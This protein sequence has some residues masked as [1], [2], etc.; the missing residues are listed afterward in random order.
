MTLWGFLS[1]ALWGQ[2]PASPSTPAQPVQLLVGEDILTIKAVHQE[3]TEKNKYLL[4][5][6]VEIDYQDMKFLADEMTY[7][8]QSGDVEATGHVHFERAVERVDG[9]RLKMNMI[10]KTG[11]IFD[12]KGIAR[13]DL[14]FEGREIHKIGEN[15]YKLI[16]GTVTACKGDV[17]RWSFKAKSATVNVEKSVFMHDAMFR[18]KKVPV[19]FSPY[20]AAPVTKRERQTGFLIPSTGSSTQKGRTFSD[21]FFWAINRSADLLFTGEYFSSRGW[22]Q[23]IQFRARPSAEN[24]ISVFGFHVNDRQ[25]QGGQTAKVGA[26][27]NFANGFRA[28]ADVNYVSSLTFRQ[29]FGETFNSIVLPDQISQL[30]LTRN[31][32]E[33][34]LNFSV[35]RDETFYPQ[36][37]VTLRRFPSAEF[38]IQ[39]HL[40]AHLPFY[41]SMDSSVDGIHRTD[42]NFETANVSQRFDFAPRITFPIKNFLGGYFTPSLE[43]RD[44][45]YRERLHSV[46]PVQEMLNRLTGEFRLDFKGFALEH[47]YEHKGGW[48]GD[49]FKHVIEPEVSYRIVRGATD[50]DQIIRFDE[51]DVLV[52]TQEIE[53]G[54]TNRIFARRD[55]GSGQAREILSWKIAQKYYFDP[56]LGGAVVAGRRNV[57]DA[58][59]DLTGF[60]FA[61]GPRRFSPLVSLVRFNPRENFS[62]DFQTD[63][64]T[65]LHQMRNASVTSTIY[66]SRGFL[67]LTYF[68]TREHDPITIAS[69]QLRTTLGFGNFNKQGVSAAF[70]IAYDLKRSTVLNSV[71]Q[72]GYNWDCCGVMVEFRQFN[73][74]L[75]NETQTRFSFSLLNVGSFG[76]LKRQ[77]RLY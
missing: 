24:F 38:S 69:S 77:E 67:A 36:G 25:G 58:L 45:V 31:S 7:D 64:D 18:V 54:I 15:T 73:I 22:A 47:I 50:I 34:S 6:N 21:A 68:V 23:E 26:S 11:V 17:P 71:V 37:A 53:Y 65:R 66:D 55:S 32:G 20:L 30:F 49:R 75:R 4:K 35:A 1:P 40:Y 13:P 10:S 3:Q 43:L 59:Q 46:K 42:P 61:D 76:N 5:G 8:D 33:T 16:D 70:S 12:A 27:Y 9:S 19:F 29:V 48:F 63:Y 39:P 52:N 56:T 28:V 41:F 44:T 72:M 14:Y 74:G 57:F 62:A 60:A 51:N 2:T